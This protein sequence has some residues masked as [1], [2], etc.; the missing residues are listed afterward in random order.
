MKRTYNKLV[1]D[2]IP[3]IIEAK[4]EKPVTKILTDEEYWS[5]LFEKALEELDEVKTADDLDE[6]KKELADL[7][8]VVRAMAEHKGFSLSEIIEEADRKASER[9]KFENKIYLIG[10]K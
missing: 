4:G 3:E 1:R 6:T 9:G 2:R 5:S 8:E 7:L 10:V